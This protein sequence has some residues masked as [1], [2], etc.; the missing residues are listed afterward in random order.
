MARCR[1]FPYAQCSYKTKDA[2]TFQLIRGI[3]IKE[4]VW[5][6]ERQ[7]EVGGGGGG[8]GDNSGHRVVLVESGGV[9]VGGGVGGDNSGHWLVIVEG[10]GVGGVGGGGWWCRRAGRL[11]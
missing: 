7:W 5:E 3:E 10:G 9:G 1:G 8:G 2:C 4:N 11:S 6:G